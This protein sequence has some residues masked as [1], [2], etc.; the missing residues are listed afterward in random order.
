MLAHFRR[1]I[2]L[3]RQMIWALVMETVE[4]KQMVHTYV[5]HGSGRLLGRT[6]SKS[7]SPEEL[8]KAA[9]QIRDLPRLLPFFVLVIAP[10][11][12]VTEGYVLVAVTVERWLGQRISLLPSQFRQVF[13][14]PAPRQVVEERTPVADG[15]QQEPV[16]LPEDLA[17]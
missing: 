15:R 6:S 9:E 14:K 8:R 10:L 1:V 13:Q 2:R 5:R 7:P 11:P 16:L 3:P 17:A 4:T 12:G